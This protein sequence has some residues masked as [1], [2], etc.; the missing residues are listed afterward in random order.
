MLSAAGGT[1]AV[2][3]HRGGLDVIAHY[4]SVAAEMAVCLKAVGLADRSDLR[5]LE[6]T[7][8]EPFLDHALDAAVP[9]GVP[10]TGGAVC[11]ADTWCCRPADDRALVVGAPGAVDRWRSV[12]GRAAATTGIPVRARSLPAADALSIVGP[13]AAAV[14]DASALPSG[15]SADEVGAGALAGS[16]VLVL[17]ERDGGYMLVFPAGCGPE[18]FEALAQRGRV[19][20]MAMVGHDALARLRAAHVTAAAALN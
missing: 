14:L 5:V 4:G 18:A 11:V 1:G 17:R 15:L 12:I 10:Q 9:G 8:E 13:R 20:G 6:V 3:V 19:A 16:E 2:R 7:G